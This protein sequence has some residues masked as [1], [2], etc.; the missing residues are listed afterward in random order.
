MLRRCPL[1]SWA[2][3]GGPAAGMENGPVQRN[4]S[5]TYLGV[6]PAICSQSTEF[7]YPLYATFLQVRES[8][9]I[10]VAP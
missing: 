6:I 9:D 2:G 10:T 7:L 5:G 8:C 1:T 3:W 4:C